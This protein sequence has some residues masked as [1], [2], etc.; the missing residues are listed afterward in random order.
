M[1]GN[2]GI[3]I[4]IGKWYRNFILSKWAEEGY[5]SYVKSPQSLIVRTKTTLTQ[6]KLDEVK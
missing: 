2:E 4:E 1:I 3:T 6:P 5:N